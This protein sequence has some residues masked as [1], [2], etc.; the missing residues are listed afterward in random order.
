MDEPTLSNNL[1]MLREDMLAV[2]RVFSRDINDAEDAVQKAYMKASQRVSQFD[3]GTGFDPGARFKAWLSRIVRHCCMDILRK[4]KRDE[5]L[6]QRLRDNNGVLGPGAAR[7]IIYDKNVDATTGLSM[8]KLFGITQSFLLSPI[9]EWKEK[10]SEE[11]KSELTLKDPDNR[12]TL[13]NK[14]FIVE[15]IEWVLDSSTS[16]EEI[17]S[18]LPHN[19]QDSRISQIRVPL[20]DELRGYLL[21]HQPMRVLCILEFPPCIEDSETRSEAGVF[22][23]LTTGGEKY[24]LNDEGCVRIAKYIGKKMKCADSKGNQIEFLADTI[25]FSIEHKQLPVG[26]PHGMKLEWHSRIGDV[27]SMEHDGSKAKRIDGELE[28]KPDWGIPL[29]ITIPP[30]SPTEETDLVY[31]YRENQANTRERQ[32]GNSIDL[33]LKVRL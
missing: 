1:E 25:L 26:R 16:L 19:I 5:R 30:G 15:N 2:A 33:N 7:E 27:S 3:P 9:A 17:R 23:S 18:K 24:I 14:L 10:R 28:K 12:G 31:E 21:L 4:R 13:E 32:S 8:A 6:N 11:I 29:H 20:R 22:F